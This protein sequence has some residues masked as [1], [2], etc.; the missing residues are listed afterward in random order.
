M[1]GPQKDELDQKII[2]STKNEHT[3]IQMAMEENIS[4]AYNASVKKKVFIKRRY[5]RGARRGNGLERIRETC[6]QLGIEFSI[7]SHHGYIFYDNKGNIMKKD[8]KNNR[9]FA[10]TLYHFKIPAK[11]D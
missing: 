5:I 2:N 10:G 4:G 11:G 9:V 1:T 7:L 8:S 6:I 3:F